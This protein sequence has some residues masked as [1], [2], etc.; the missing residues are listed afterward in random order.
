MCWFSGPGMI[1]TQITAWPQTFRIPPW[2]NSRWNILRGCETDSIAE[3]PRF[4]EY[5]NH[6]L[7]IISILA[8]PLCSSKESIAFTE[9]QLCWMENHVNSEESC[10]VKEQSHLQYNCCL[11]TSSSYWID[12]L[13]HPPWGLQHPQ[14]F[15]SYSFVTQQRCP[16]MHGS[17][18]LPGLGGVVHRPCY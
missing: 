14:A 8:G 6:K 2:G 13:L 11:E 4:L 3:T 1:T 12:C 16:S 18:M 7:N 15:S 5:E 9:D 10:P 17:L